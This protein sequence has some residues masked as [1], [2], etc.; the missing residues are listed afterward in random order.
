[1]VSHIMLIRM[2]LDRASAAKRVWEQ[3]LLPA[4]QAEPGFVAARLLIS[5]DAPSEGM[6][7]CI[8]ETQG[9]ADAALRSSAV[10]QEMQQLTAHLS[11]PPP[12]RSYDLVSES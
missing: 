10:Q 7:F 4:L 3:A 5:A 2:A 9:A 8:W 1:M 12:I 6:H 11:E